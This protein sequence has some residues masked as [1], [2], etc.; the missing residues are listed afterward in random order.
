MQSPIRLRAR[1]ISIIAISMMLTACAQLMPERSPPSH[2]QMIDDY[3]K[4]INSNPSGS[5]TAKIY[6]WRGFEYDLL[7]KYSKAIEDY[8]K[9]IS[10]DPKAAAGM[11][12]DRT[13]TI[14]ERAWIGCMVMLVTDSYV[15]PAGFRAVA[16]TCWRS[17][18]T[19]P[20]PLPW[21]SSAGNGPESAG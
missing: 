1:I 16:G 17:C 13:M 14:K 7:R 12:T 10:L 20:V 6:F 11:P 9:S 21:T 4:R 18:P 19:W 2:Q 5:E 3:T 8:N 15:G